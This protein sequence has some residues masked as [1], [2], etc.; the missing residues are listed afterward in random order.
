MT[1]ST[2]RQTEF[3][4]CARWVFLNH[5]AVA[6]LSNR[7]RRAMEWLLDDV[8]R[9]GTANA[10]QWHQCYQR[11]REAAARLVGAKPTD[12]ALLKNTTEGLGVVANGLDWRE[13]D[14]VVS[15]NVEFPANIYPWMNLARRGVDLRLV[16]ERDGRVPFEDIEAA[17]DARTRVLALS[18]VE[19]GSGFRHD[20]ERLGALCASRGVLFVVD[21]IQGLGV[22]PVDV[23]AQQID[24]LSADGHKWLLAP[25]GCALFY[26]TPALR[27]QLEVVNV[28]WWGVV[29]AS[30]Y[31]NYD[32]TLRPDARRFESGTLN[33]VGV[34][35]LTAA[36]E[37]LLELDLDRVAARVLELT[38]HLCEGLLGKGCELLSSRV[39]G[40]ASGIVSFVSPSEDPR[41]FVTRAEGEGII[42]A[43]RDRRV[44]VSPH[45]YNDES[46]LNALLA[47]L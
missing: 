27:E 37:L 3:P 6:P 2:L 15:C 39:A 5:A 40:E 1:W 21:A 20:L 8:T 44:R 13:G 12:I 29:N 17:L 24:A 7:A 45:C 23:A 47:L 4:I 22:F 14:N 43:C 42:I 32:F 33:T 36:I 11:C 46:D 38:D 16:P 28:G 41:A 35:G 31:L 10:G 9:N 25:E 30:D 18:F 26:C 19:F 34:Y